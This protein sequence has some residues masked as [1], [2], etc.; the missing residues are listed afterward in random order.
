MTD[1]SELSEPVLDGSNDATREQKIAGLVRQVDADLTLLPQEDLLTELRLRLSDAGITV[2]EDE[3]IA[4][5][6]TI[7]LGR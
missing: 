7:A 1:S 2:E 6:G 3:L 5:A 4:I